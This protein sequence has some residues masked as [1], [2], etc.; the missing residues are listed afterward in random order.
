MALF[1]D[2][3]LAAK[4]KVIVY[5]ARIIFAQCCSIAKD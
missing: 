4:V 2:D 3:Q 1:P 5:S